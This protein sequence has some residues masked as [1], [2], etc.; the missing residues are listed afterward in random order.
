MIAEHFRTEIRQRPD[1]LGHFWSLARRT[2]DPGI[3][4]RIGLKL[5]RGIFR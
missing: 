2:W 4:N 5:N 1:L 3:R